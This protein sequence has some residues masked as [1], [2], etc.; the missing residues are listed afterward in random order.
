MN[1]G[2][3]NGELHKL[4]SLLSV[5]LNSTFLSRGNASA[6]LTPCETWD[7]V[8]RWVTRREGHCTVGSRHPTYLTLMGLHFMPQSTLLLILPRPCPF[9]SSSWSSS[10]G[11]SLPSLLSLSLLS[12]IRLD[13]MGKTPQKPRGNAA[14]RG[15]GVDQK[16]WPESRTSYATTQER[17]RARQHWGRNVKTNLSHSREKALPNRPL[18]P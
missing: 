11:W 8:K 15:S 5:C 4:G 3:T 1:F 14:S 9:S 10:H 13:K 2:D 12:G 7:F 16:V 17:S 6:L 18:R